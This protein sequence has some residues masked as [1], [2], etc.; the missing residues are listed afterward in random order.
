[1]FLQGNQFPQFNIAPPLPGTTLVLARNPGGAP[2]ECELTGCPKI[3]IPIPIEVQRTCVSELSSE[4]LDPK[5][6]T[7]G[8]SDSF[9][10]FITYDAIEPLV[11]EWV[12]RHPWLAKLEDSGGRTPV[13]VASPAIKVRHDIRVRLRLRRCG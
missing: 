1:M 10:Q 4:T 2:E 7:T 6:I 3:V 13:A 9:F 12:K 5:S 11:A 8:A